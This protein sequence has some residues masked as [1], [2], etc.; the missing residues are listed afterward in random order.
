MGRRISSAKL[1]L[2]NRKSS[3]FNPPEFGCLRGIA[4]INI[5]KGCAH[6]CV[7]CYA[8]GFPEAPP[9]GEVYL[10]KNLPELVEAELWKKKTLP[11][12]VS[13]STAS[14]LFQPYD[15]ILDV[16]YRVLKILLEAGIGV[17]FLTKGIAPQDFIDLFKKYPG[18]VKARIGLVSLNE[19]YRRV[20]EPYTASGSDRL[21]FIKALVDASV[22]VSVRVDPVVPYLVDS[23]DE[24]ERLFRAVVNIGVK[25]IALSCLIMRPTIMQYMRE[26]IPE[27]VFK[28]II[29]YYKRQPYQRVITSAKT[30]LLPISYR[31]SL[32][33][34][35]RS[36]AKKQTISMKICGC[37]NP[38]LPWQNCQPW[39]EPDNVCSLQRQ[40]SLFNLELPVVFP[41]G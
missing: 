10:Y 27:G 32:Y 28:R 14:D 26:A 37:K 16:S 30:K 39:I 22:E 24:L 25:N 15:E 33:K 20:F 7:Y 41:R 19:Q 38:D 3:P 6:G 29:G 2:I 9:D 35:A 8:R 11:N 18:K 5:T 17:V 4:S 13:F 40:Q 23:S 21:E 31:I 34:R 36:I 1:K 12:W